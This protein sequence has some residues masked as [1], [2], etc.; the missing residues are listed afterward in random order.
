MKPFENGVGWYTSATLELHF[1]QD[2]VCCAQCPFCKPET[3]GS[4]IERHWCRAN[5][6]NLIQADVFT[7]VPEDCPLHI[8]RKV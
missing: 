1:P 4:R 8:E 7:G 3:I 6:N 2:D 5:R